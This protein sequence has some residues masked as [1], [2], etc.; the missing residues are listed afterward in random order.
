MVVVVPLWPVQLSAYAREQLTLLFQLLDTDHNGELVRGERCD[1][2]SF[3]V[4]ACFVR[5]G[6]AGGAAFAV[7]FSALLFPIY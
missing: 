4:M 3:L 7:P 6:F 5:G 2:A 1:V